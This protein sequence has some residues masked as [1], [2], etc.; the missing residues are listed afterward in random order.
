[1]SLI[2]CHLQGRSPDTVW[3]NEAVTT[4][5]LLRD[6]SRGLITEPRFHTAMRRLSADQSLDLV[7]AIRTLASEMKR[8]SVRHMLEGCPAAQS[9]ALV[10]T[11][12][13]LACQLP[14]SG[15]P[16]AEGCPAVQSPDLVIVKTLQ[17]KFPSL[18]A[19]PTKLLASPVLETATLLWMGRKMLQGLRFGQS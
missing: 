10:L 9:P 5:L 6:Q 8:P 2:C 1:M 11:I 12:Q 7:T 14:R 17:T 3:Q 16:L 15:S 4:S 19:G 13:L 18:P